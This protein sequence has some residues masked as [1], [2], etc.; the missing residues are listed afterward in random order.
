MAFE[1]RFQ[2][3]WAHLDGN[4]HMAN[5]AFVVLAI[6]TRF[7]YFQSRGFTPAEFRAAAIG[8]VV[9][10]DEVDYF[11]E[12][13]FLETVRINLLIAGL[14]DDCSRFRLVNE[15]HRENGELCAR[16]TSEG[17]W[18]DLRARKLAA[19]PQALAE[20]LRAIERTPDFEVLKSSVSGRP[21]AATRTPG[22]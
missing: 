9:R 4:G 10:R 22:G 18:L 20:A 16:L 14:S 6:E 8:P 19:P 13:H 5:T 15:F 17:G 2:I 3:G 21:S 11:R 1:H 12:L 7:L